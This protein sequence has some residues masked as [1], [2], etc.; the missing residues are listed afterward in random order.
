L[1][2][3]KFANAFCLTV[4]LAHELRLIRARKTDKKH[5]QTSG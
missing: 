5:L 3:T 1:R 2:L 4:L